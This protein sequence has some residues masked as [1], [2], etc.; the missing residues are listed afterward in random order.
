MKSEKVLE[1]NLNN[2]NST[3]FGDFDSQD[4]PKNKNKND[5]FDT[6]VINF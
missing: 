1:T 6:K 2:D 4:S 3:V 5:L